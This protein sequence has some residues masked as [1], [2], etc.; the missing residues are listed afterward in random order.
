MP[1]RYALGALSRVYLRHPVEGHRTIGELINFVIGPAAR[2]SD[3][4]VHQKPSD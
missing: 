4:P 2:F 1:F 3:R